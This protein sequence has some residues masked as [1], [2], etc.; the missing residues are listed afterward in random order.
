MYKNEYTIT[1][2]WGT[3]PP[4]SKTFT[5]E[6]YAYQVDP[7]FGIISPSSNTVSLTAVPCYDWVTVTFEDLI[8]TCLS[9][10]ASINWCVGH[11]GDVPQNM[12]D[13][14]PFYRE[15]PY[16]GHYDDSN[17]CSYGTLWTND[18][19]INIGYGGGNFVLCKEMADG[20]CYEV[21]NA[22]Y[23]V[24]TN[25]LWIP[26]DATES[27]VIGMN[28]YD[29]D[30]YND[31]RQCYAEYR[32]TPRDLQDIAALSNHRETYLKYFSERGG[33]SCALRFTIHLLKETPPSEE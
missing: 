32:F 7:V 29:N 1:D 30:R 17:G 16:I 25:K 31:D 27:L 9:G 3:Y 20:S 6:V 8:L 33:G 10:D 23:T 15:C 19:R 2:T 13:W 11:T 21:E 5:Y 12:I 18:K 4:C 14:W 28:W 22:C 24:T 26:L